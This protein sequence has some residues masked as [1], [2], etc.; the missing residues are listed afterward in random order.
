MGK[1][2]KEVTRFYFEKSFKFLM[3]II[4]SLRRKWVNELFA[5]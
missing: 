3:I 2:E 1:L 5:F 4:C